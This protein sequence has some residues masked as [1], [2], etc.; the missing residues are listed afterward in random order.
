[1]QAIL[2]LFFMAIL[3]GNS[4]VV[5]SQVHD[6]H[7]V[8]GDGATDVREQIHQLCGTPPG[9]AID[10]NFTCQPQARDSLIELASSRDQSIVNAIIGFRAQLPLEARVMLHERCRQ[11]ENNDERMFQCQ[12]DNLGPALWHGHNMGLDLPAN[13]RWQDCAPRSNKEPRGLGKMRSDFQRDLCLTY[14]DHLKVAKES[15]N[16]LKAHLLIK[17]GIGLA[18]AIASGRGHMVSVGSGDN[19]RVGYEGQTSGP[20]FPPLADG[21][22]NVSMPYA[23]SATRQFPEDGGIGAQEEDLSTNRAGIWPGRGGYQGVCHIGFNWAQDGMMR[24]ETSMR[25]EVCPWLTQQDA[26]S[27]F[28]PELFKVMTR[29]ESTDYFELLRLEAA[30]RTIRAARVQ[31]GDIPELKAVPETCAPITSAYQRSLTSQLSPQELR[32]QSLNTNTDYPQAVQSAAKRIH[33]KLAPEA[34]RLESELTQV[35]VAQAGISMGAADDRHSPTLHAQNQEMLASLRARQSVIQQRLNEIQEQILA[36]FERYPVLM[37]GRDHDEDLWESNPKVAQLAQVSS[38]QLLSTY[39]AAKREQVT[40]TLSQIGDICN[41]KKVNDEQLIRDKNL[42]QLVLQKYPRF[43]TLHRCVSDQ[44]ESR[45]RTVRVLRVGAALSCIAFGP[46]GGAICGGLIAVGGG[47]MDYERAQ[48][49]LSYEGQ[50]RMTMGVSNAM[51]SSEDYLSAQ[52]EMNDTIRNIVID[53]ALEILLPVAGAS[54]RV[55]SAA[56]IRQFKVALE[57]AETTSDIRRIAT[58]MEQAAAD[59]R[60][61]LPA[62]N[63]PPTAAALVDDVADATKPGRTSLPVRNTADMPTRPI[64]NAAPHPHPPII[65]TSA[66]RRARVQNVD[67]PAAS[68]S[69]VTRPSGNR[70]PSLPHP[71]TPSETRVMLRA[72][73]GAIPE[74]SVLDA[75]YEMRIPHVRYTPSANPID[76]AQAFLNSEQFKASMPGMDGMT[77]T[78]DASTELGR[79]GTRRVFKLTGDDRF[80]AKIYDGSMNGLKELP[81]DVQGKIIQGMIQRELALEDMLMQV[82]D[83]YRRAGLEPPFQ[84]ARIVRDPELLRRGII[85][86]ERYTGQTLDTLS[87]QQLDNL[88]PAAAGHVP[89]PTRTVTYRGKERLVDDQGEFVSKGGLAHRELQR[90]PGVDAYQQFINAYDV[91]IREA[92]AARL[93]IGVSTRGGPDMVRDMGMDVGNGYG[94]VMLDP[95]GPGGVARTII[96]DW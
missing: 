31:L 7:G 30:A 73:P 27:G 21:A 82:A 44:L 55:L 23:P 70:Q 50:C 92:I 2:R 29:I 71:V 14:A 16:N 41:P 6:L 61:L 12:T 63:P 13:A 69:E 76:E 49:R 10:Q 60:R 34:E 4:T 45:D 39:Q 22:L 8:A 38:S 83:N 40:A 19:R 74:G 15:L 68:K 65:T 51:C 67:P 91:K 26:L 64:L 96:Y 9:S 42:T 25:S 81:P 5:F 43:E 77:A 47:Y 95:D 24:T 57:G 11:H 79:G 54:L 36:D 17:N 89:P 85:L 33:E 58:E 46:V 3:I 20:C 87:R 32:L 28:A 94:N 18:C 53:G 72:E 90:L 84:V 93:E 1:L 62:A 56:R 37:V 78:L 48:T 86:Q 52:G 80:V 59:A 75:S 66:A 35:R 88:A